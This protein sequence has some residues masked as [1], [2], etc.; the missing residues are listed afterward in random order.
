MKN[1]LAVADFGC[2]VTKPSLVTQPCVLPAIPQSILL[3][4]PLCTSL[5]DLSFSSPYLNLVVQWRQVD[6]RQKPVRAKPLVWVF[7]AAVA[8][9]GSQVTESVR[10]T[11]EM[12]EWK[13]WV[14]SASLGPP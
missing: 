5:C 10:L 3:P 1:D 9:L 2:G 13:V 12:T 14:Y 4:A 8:F 6:R 11:S 7:A